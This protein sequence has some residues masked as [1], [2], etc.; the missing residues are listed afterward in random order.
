MKKRILKK[1]N[2]QLNKKERFTY[3]HMRFLKY[4]YQKFKTRPV[5]LLICYKNHIYIDRDCIRKYKILSNCK[6]TA[7]NGQK[8]YPNAQLGG[9]DMLY[10]QVSPSCKFKKFQDTEIF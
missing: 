6:I 8:V 2:N 9:Q 4:I 3:K 10:V 1:W 5:W 7:I